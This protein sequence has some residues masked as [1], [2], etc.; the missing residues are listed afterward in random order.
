MQATMTE[1]LWKQIRYF[2]IDSKIDKWGDP[3][4]M[5]SNLVFTIDAFRHYVG[6][7][8]YVHCGWELRDTGWHP[9]GNAVDCH[10]KGMS[11][12]DQFLAASRFDRFNGIGIYKYWRNPGLHLDDR[13]HRLKRDIDARWICLRKGEYVSLNANNFIKLF[14]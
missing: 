6:R 11:L 3:L 4:K 1:E 2:P 8:V 10:V 14:S 13:P 7:P 5:S 12:V 9:S